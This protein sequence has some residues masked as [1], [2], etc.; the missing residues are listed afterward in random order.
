MRRCS[1]IVARPSAVPSSRQSRG[2]SPLSVLEHA[3]RQLVEVDDAQAKEVGL[4]RPGERQQVVDHAGHPLELVRDELHRPPPVFRI[5]AHE[6]EVAADHRDRRAQL[7][8]G[9]VDEPALRREGGLEPLE[10]LVE[11]RPI[12]RRSRRSRGPGSAG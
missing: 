5:V 10:H 9:V 11:R 12:A 6:L 4:L 2:A 7:V 1:S 3:D 8:A